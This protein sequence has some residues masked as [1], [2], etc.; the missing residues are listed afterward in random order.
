MALVG[1]STGCY[2]LLSDRNL[3]FDRIVAAVIA[4]VALYRDFGRD[5][6]RIDLNA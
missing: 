3:D 5:V 1:N 2:C 4:A 6:F